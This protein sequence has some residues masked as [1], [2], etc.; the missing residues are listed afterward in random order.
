L[1]IEPGPVPIPDSDAIY[2]AEPNPTGN[3]VGGGVGY[4]RI[5]AQSDPRVNYVVS[6][7][8]QLLTALKNAKSGEVVFIPQTASIDLS[9]TYTTIIPAGVTLAGDR[10]F[11]G[12]LGGKILRHRVAADGT[13][14]YKIPTL[15]A[16]GDNVRITGLQ[17]QGFDVNQDQELESVGLEIQSAIKATGR[18]GLEVDNCEIWG[19]S[20]AGVALENSGSAHIHHNSIHHCQARGYGYGVSVSGGTA[21][22]EANKFDYTRHAIMGSG[23]PNEGYE[24]RYNIHLGHGDAIGGHHFDVHAYPDP[25]TGQSIAGSEY[26][27]HHNTFE[28]TRLYSIGVRA[29]P[30][31]RVWIDHNIF[32]SSFT[33]VFQRGNYPDGVF[34]GYGR[35]SMTNNLIGSNQTFYAEGPIELV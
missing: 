13:D 9:G 25:V 10:G 8:D 12:S 14:Y 18:S 23:Y 15:I 11:Q 3:P 17:I 27:I 6:T 22:I 30:E 34:V 4:T 2:G 33:P 32:K 29:V 1:I 7:K 21:L 16:G 31:K 20:H 26:K 5:I 28:E 24:A 35:I 19:W